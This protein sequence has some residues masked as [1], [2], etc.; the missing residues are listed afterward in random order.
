MERNK[1]MSDDYRLNS[2]SLVHSPGVVPYFIE[3][4]KTGNDKQKLNAI[5]GLSAWDTLPASVILDV[6]R[7]KI[8]YTVD[9]DVVIIPK[10]A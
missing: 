9:G 1:K 2:S 7:E 6:L 5:E 4:Y 8:E 10:A 3:M